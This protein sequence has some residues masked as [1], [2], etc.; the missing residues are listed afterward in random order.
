[1][2]S[3]SPFITTV[4]ALSVAVERVVEVLK[5]TLGSTPMGSWLFAA[6]PSSPGLENLRC[7]G[8]YVLSGVIG[9]L[10]SVYSG[11]GSTIPIHSSHPWMGDIL[12]GLLSSGGSSFWNH[13][14]DIM[15]ASKVVKE[16]AA[17]TAV[18]N[19]AVNT[20]VTNAQHLIA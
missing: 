19:N 15:K 11:L 10:I 16:Q 17:V 5:Q 7:A 13:A 2:G 18:A 1:M 4:L 3:L 8:L 9:S 12:M 14:L 20:N 6:K